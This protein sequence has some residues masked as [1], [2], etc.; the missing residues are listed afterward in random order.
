[1]ATPSEFLI[2]LQ[3]SQDSISWDDV[4]YKEFINNLGGLKKVTEL[5]LKN[6]EYTKQN[7]T[8]HN[9][10]ALDKLLFKSI[11]D[12]NEHD[13]KK[14][15]LSIPSEQMS[16]QN[17]NIVNIDKSSTI[18][19]FNKEK[20][21]YAVDATNNLYF[22][23]LPNETAC[24]IYYDILLD[25]RFA[26]ASVA[27]VMGF[28]LATQIIRSVVGMNID[29]SLLAVYQTFWLS[30]V[31]IGSIIC[32]LYLFSVNIK[33]FNLIIRSFDFWF[34]MYNLVLLL[35][36]NLLLAL[37]FDKNPYAASA[38]YYVICVFVIL[39]FA[40]LVDGAFMPLKMKF[41]FLICCAI[42]FLY[43]AIR[44]F[45]ILDDN[46]AEW[47]PFLS[48]SQKH[49][50]NTRINFK[51]LYI[52]SAINLSI[53]SAKPVFMYFFKKRKE[54]CDCVIMGCHS[55][56]GNNNQ[57]DQEKKR[58]RK[59][60][61]K[62]YQLNWNETQSTTVFK[63]PF[64]QWQNLDRSNRNVEMTIAKKSTKLNQNVSVESNSVQGNVVTLT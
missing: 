2:K 45:F 29:G 49:L 60:K 47:N 26:I 40:F 8:T 28:I 4:H 50:K 9:I 19:R 46:D 54:I 32:L 64:F 13:Y 12:Q 10:A 48:Y 53:F 6:E 1:M 39:I 24:L 34:K 7:I 23:Y 51:S 18:D 15:Q 14:Q 44:L 59:R 3:R 27:V 16:A 25:R 31:S 11:Y 42:Y 30:G 33:I 43:L 22:C 38:P 21:V 37:H 41:I 17:T 61:K 58:K 20:S 62:K 63:R 57:R 52:S 5:C 55:H 36:S 35:S 56:S